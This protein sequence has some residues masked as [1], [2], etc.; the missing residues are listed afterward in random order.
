[1]VVVEKNVIWLDIAMDNLLRVNMMDATQN[2]VRVELHFGKIYCSLQINFVMQVPAP[3]KR[4]E[5]LHLISWVFPALICIVHINNKRMA[6]NNFHQLKLFDPFKIIN[7]S[8]QFYDI[9]I[10]YNIFTALC[11]ELRRCWKKSYSFFSSSRYFYC[12]FWVDFFCR[13]LSSLL[14]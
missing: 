7:F 6:W 5:N 13:R 11:S 10:S 2:L 8:F 3:I 9:Y 12:F 14:L 1:M 4:H